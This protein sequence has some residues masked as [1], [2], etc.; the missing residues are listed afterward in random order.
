[1]LFPDWK[2]GR[3]TFNASCLKQQAIGLHV[4]SYSVC[5]ELTAWG[6]QMRCSNMLVCEGRELLNNLPS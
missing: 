6:L 3:M 1:M 5:I 2:A 4:S